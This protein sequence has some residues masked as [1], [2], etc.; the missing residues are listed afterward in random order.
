M[1]KTASSNVLTVIT[2]ILIGITILFNGGVVGAITGTLLWIF[3]PVTVV[4]YIK[5]K[6]ASKGADKA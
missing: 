2:L 3:I 6:K 4:T 5:E 1:K